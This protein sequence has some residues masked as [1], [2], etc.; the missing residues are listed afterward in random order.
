LLILSEEHRSLYSANP[1]LDWK[2]LARG[3]DVQFVP[4]R[5]PQMFAEPGVQALAG[6]LS[7]ALLAART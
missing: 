7:A 4:G 3:Y 5:D 2:D 1:L 6:H